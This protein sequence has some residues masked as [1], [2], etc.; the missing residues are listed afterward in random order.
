MKI[1]SNI[2]MQ[3]RRDP[4]AP[5]PAHD[6]LRRAAKSDAK[7]QARSVPDSFVGTD[8]LY[9]VLAVSQ[10]EVRLES[11]TS[12]RA[13]ALAK[14]EAAEE[15]ATGKR[16]RLVAVERPISQQQLRALTA[17]DAAVSEAQAQVRSVRAV[18]FAV[19]HAEVALA[20][21]LSAIFNLAAVRELPSDVV[22]NF[23][24]SAD[25]LLVELPEWTQEAEV[26]A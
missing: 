4:L 10:A 7:K 15:R 12:A 14:A 19:A 6:R 5:W 1:L 24:P 21:E 17:A 18:S 20:T 23:K 3:L 26:A 8:C 2:S 13:S 16:D 25:R 22:A 11:L 9:G